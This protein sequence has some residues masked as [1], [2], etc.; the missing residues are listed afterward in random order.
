[1]SATLT[2]KLV[3]KF[4]LTSH[5]KRLKKVMVKLKLWPSGGFGY[6]H[7]KQAYKLLSGR[8]LEVGAL[9]CPANLPSRCE[10]EYCDAHSKD[11][12]AKLFPEIERD[13]L[14][15]VDYI[16]DLDKDRLFDKV[17]PFYD[18]VIMNHVIEHVA[19]PMAVLEQLFAVAKPGG[20]VLI[21]APDKDYTFDKPRQLTPFE[22]LRSEYEQKIQFV[23]DSHY[24]DFIRHTAPDIF[25]SGDTVL[26]ATTLASVRER[27]EHAHVWDS[28]SFLDFLSRSLD[29]LKI[30]ATLEVV[31]KAGSNNIECFTLLKKVDA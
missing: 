25:N 31:S 15:D 6:A 4:G 9:H 3:R 11:D 23:D 1:M 13:L 28:E 17:K 5:V 2:L 14:V 26:L 24:L 29:F 22:H 8:G 12:A 27:R 10:I 16:V 7:R 30:S 21:S 20:Y 18:F 19:N